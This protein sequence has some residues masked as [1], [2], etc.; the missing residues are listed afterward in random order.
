[1]RAKLAPVF[2]AACMTVSASAVWAASPEKSSPQPDYTALLHY[3][4]EPAGTLEDPDGHLYFGYDGVFDRGGESLTLLSSAGE[5]LLPGIDDIDYLGGGLYEARL[6]LEESNVNTTG[7]FTTDGQTLIPCE[8][9]S[10]VLPHNRDD[11]SARFLGVI[12]TTEETDN[13]DECIIYFTS[14]MISLSVGEEDVMYKGYAKIFDLAA[15]DFVPNVE[16]SSLSRNGMNDLGDSFVLEHDN[17]CTMYDADGNVLWETDGMLMDAGYSTVLVSTGGKDYIVDA[18]GKD[19]FASDNS[20][21]LINAPMDYYSI[22]DDE[23]EH[24]YHMIDSTGNRISENTYSIIYDSEGCIYQT[25]DADDKYIAVSEDGSVL[26]GNIST[27]YY[28]LGGYGYIEQEDSELY[29]A[30]TPNGLIEDL[31]GYQPTNLIF[32]KGTDAIA[33]N[34]GEVF[35]SDVEAQDLRV[36]RPA[37]VSAY[38]TS[39]SGSHYAVYDFF[40]G[41]ELLPA[42]YD[43][44]YAAGDYLYA[45]KTDS[46]GK[47]VWSVYKICLTAAD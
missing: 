10:I 34:T 9:A 40:T 37:L 17:I 2:V 29:C 33:L 21:G 42:E 16:L 11:G 39:S 4:L 25:K 8:A 28:S 13:E 47:D 18:S 46:T 38:I 19:S 12:Y 20:I 22:Y 1:M 27:L 15:G 30:V 36:L 3:E 5:E 14:D 31:E 24:P 6:P 32:N 26:A 35:A 44:V 43:D 7:L 45:N 23:S 41:E